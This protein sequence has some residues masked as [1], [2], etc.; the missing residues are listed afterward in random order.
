MNSGSM[1]GEH[2]GKKW[3]LRFNSAPGCS[4]II[5]CWHGRFL[6]IEVKRPGGKTDPKRLALQLQF[7]ETIRKAGGVAFFAESLQDV[8]D[9]LNEAKRELES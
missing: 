7:Q 6:A 5:A 9:K 3:F 8:I 4:D 1:A 2:K